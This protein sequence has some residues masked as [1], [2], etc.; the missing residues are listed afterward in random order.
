ME[1]DTPETTDIFLWA[2][3]TDAI[4]N[5]LEM[6][7]FLFNKNYTPFSLRFSS[8]LERQI[9]VLFLYDIVNDVNLGAGTGLSVRDF[10][11]SDAEEGVLLRTELEKVGRAATLLNLIETQRA[12]IVEFSEEEHEFKRMKGMIVRFSKKDAPDKPFF[13]VKAIQQANSLKGSVAW[14]ING[15]RMDAFKAD[16]GLKI[17]ADNQALIVENDIFIFNQKKFETLFQYDY[18]KQLL[19]DAKVAEIEKQYKLS[20]PQ[21]LDLQTLVRDRKKI[22][23][24]LQKLEIGE[25]PQEKALE[26]AD[27]MQLELMTDDSG[28]III[29]DGNDLDMFV[30][31]INEDYI[32]R[33]IT[34]KRYEIKSKK[35]LGE[36]EGEPPR[37]I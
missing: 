14:E 8:D 35:L 16:I 19:A 22:V 3:Q 6:E 24:K 23:T 12:E 2:N 1:K 34:G 7:V 21:G 18:K 10:E 17:P 26:Y 20:F 37:G 9:R 33:E 13:I 4:K 5:D 36:P 27:D 11:L 15:G 28:A 32:T 25:I 29:M 30:N 31:L